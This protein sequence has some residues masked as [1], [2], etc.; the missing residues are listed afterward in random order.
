[1]KVILQKDIKG[2][3]K[4]GDI[5]NVSDGHG[6]NYLIPRGLAKEA[7]AGSVS[8]NKHQKSSKKKREAEEF[9]QAKELC[10][11]IETLNLKFL[12]KAGGGSRL[13][14]SITTKDVADKLK[15]DYD[16]EI[17]KRK[18]SMDQIKM[19]GEFR[20]DI[21]VHPKVVAKLSIFVEEE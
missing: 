3:G 19:L 5:V 20:A 8:A 16:I 9:E 2:T 17:D 21:K 11:K 15:K 1:M 6:R 18:I 14:G 13:F 4:K 10:K 7:T 12:S